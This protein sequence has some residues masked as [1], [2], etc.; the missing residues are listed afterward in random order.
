MEYNMANIEIEDPNQSDFL[1][2]I[3][4]KLS[5]SHQKNW[6]IAIKTEF[7]SL[8]RAVIARRLRDEQEL[9][10]RSAMPESLRPSS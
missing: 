5:E 10:G 8:R 2:E 1:L 9:Q 7:E 4:C 6:D 3:C